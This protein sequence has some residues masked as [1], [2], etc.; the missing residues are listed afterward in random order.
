MSYCTVYDAV[1]A[2]SLPTDF[3]SMLACVDLKLSSVSLVTASASSATS[4]SGGT[5][6]PLSSGTFDMV[7]SLF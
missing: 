3:P 4:I 6:L 5:R 7:N 1:G 2:P